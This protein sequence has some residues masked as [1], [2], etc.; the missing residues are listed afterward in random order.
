MSNLRDQ[1][2]SAVTA[3]EFCSDNLLSLNEWQ[4]KKNPEGSKVAGALGFKDSNSFLVGHNHELLLENFSEITPIYV[5][6]EKNPICTA[7]ELIDGDKIAVSIVGGVI[8]KT[9]L[10]SLNLLASGISVFDHQQK[11]RIHNKWLMF[12]EKIENFFTIQKFYQAKTPNLVVCPGLEPTLDPFSVSLKMNNIESKLFLPTSPEL[13]L[14]KI[15]SQGVSE[16]FEITPCFRNDEAGKHHQPEF[17]MLEWYRSYKGVAAL[18][19]DIKK[20]I[21]FIIPNE[22]QP[23]YRIVTVKELFKKYYNFD[24]SPKTTQTE[25]YNLANNNGLSVSVNDTFDDIYFLLFVDKIENNLGQ[26]GVDF[27]FNYPPSQAA[28]AK[29]N[30]EGWADRFEMYWQGYE[31]ANAF[32]EL[33]CPE[34]QN[35]RFIEEQKNRDHLGKEFIP[36]DKEFIESL[37]YGLPPTAGIAMGLERLFMACYGLKDIKS[38]KQF[39]Y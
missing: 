3:Q 37:N 16:I 23:E 39:P 9:W 33:V 4:L 36:I 32:N 5:E 31:I 38:I 21:Q 14:K 6:G 8:E 19:K 25:L 1:L 24:L 18:I 22:E 28:L 2:I 17:T 20:L 13:H 34:K 15:I 11:W 27:L 26:G 35:N 30:K 12:L 10:I 29:I 7:K